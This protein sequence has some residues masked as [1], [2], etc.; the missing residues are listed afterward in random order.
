[1]TAASF[2]NKTKRGRKSG[3]NSSSIHFREP[4]ARLTRRSIE[5]ATGRQGS[6][7]ARYRFTRPPHPSQDERQPEI[8]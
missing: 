3:G 2:R 8:H 6:S 7:A 5:T 1:M 4:A